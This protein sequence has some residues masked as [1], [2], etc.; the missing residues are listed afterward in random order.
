MAGKN[1]ST[2]YTAKGSDAE[3]EGGGWQQRPAES[4]EVGEGAQAED[5]PKNPAEARPEARPD[6]TP[7]QSAPERQSTMDS[8]G[9]SHDRKAPRGM[10]DRSLQAQLGRQLRSI[11]SDIASEPVPE[12][13]VKLLEELEAREKHR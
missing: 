2:S 6:D 8:Q 10:L 5:D 12:R 13:F 9:P 11:Y 1:G 7:H 4:G 3:E